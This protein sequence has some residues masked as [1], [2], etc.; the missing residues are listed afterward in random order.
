MK[1]NAKKV[2][3]EDEP[4]DV[5]SVTDVAS[6]SGSTSPGPSTPTALNSSIIS[7]EKDGK[8]SN[9]AGSINNLVTVDAININA[10]LEPLAGRFI[11]FHNVFFLSLRIVMSVIKSIIFLYQILDWRLIPSFSE[12]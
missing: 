10:F 8:S 4:S 1:K 2:V 6:V 12:Q 9:Q 11:S 3:D 7:S 5:T